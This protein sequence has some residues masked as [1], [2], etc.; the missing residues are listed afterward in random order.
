MDPK[1][2]K[3]IKDEIQRLLD[4]RFVYPIEHIDWASLIM[5]TKK[6]N[7]K[8]RVCVDFKKVNTV[9]RCDHFPLPF[10]MHGLEWVAGK[11][12]YSFLDDFFE[13]N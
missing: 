7:G 10:T 8:I 13:Y 12:A 2:T 9:M 4:V 3:L 1:Y 6:K 5:I 11:E